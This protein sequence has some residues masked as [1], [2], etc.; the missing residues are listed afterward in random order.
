MACKE[1]RKKK[2]SLTGRRRDNRCKDGKEKRQKIQGGIFD[3][4]ALLK[5][6]QLCQERN[7]CDGGRGRGLCCVWRLLLHHVANVFRINW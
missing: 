1:K 2:F 7:R 4:V 3:G 5:A 6:E